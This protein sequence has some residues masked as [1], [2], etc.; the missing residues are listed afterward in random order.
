[1][2]LVVL[3]AGLALLLAA[4]GTYGV[5]SYTVAQRTREFGVRYALGARNGQVLKAVMRQ[6]MQLAG[7]GLALGIV[8]ALA[9]HK[10]MAGLLFSV[11]PTD[12]SIYGGVLVL[13]GSVAAAAAYFPARRAARVDPS[14]ALRTE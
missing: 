9:L 10:L 14:T 12:L 8:G 6:A 11:A 13:L 4:I 5:L 2:L 1:M 7:G 3:F